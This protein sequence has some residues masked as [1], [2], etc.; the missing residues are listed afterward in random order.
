MA[1]VAI[2][3][4]GQARRWGGRAKSQVLVE[5]R[6]ILSRQLEAA[7][8]LTDDVM[9]VGNHKLAEDA[10]L[11][12]V[13][14]QRPGCGPLGGLEAALTRAAGDVVLL[15][16]DLP[17]VTGPMLAYL[18]SLRTSDVDVVIPSTGER[19][20]PLCG[21]YARHSRAA[22]TRRLDEGHLR[23]LDLL[24]DVRVRTVTPEE[25]TPFG[26]P[27]HLLTN[28]NS[29]TDLDALASMSH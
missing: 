21:V 19:I 23:M 24:G 13:Q 10:Q 5:G 26:Q 17:F 4:G 2:L 7:K 6:T 22:V 20:H 1:S 3:V 28:L 29:Q 8:F 14:D 16:C 25:L 9:L 15:A 18:A 11:T 12:A 27:T